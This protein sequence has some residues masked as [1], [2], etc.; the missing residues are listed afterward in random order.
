MCLEPQ[1]H[2]AMHGLPACFMKIVLRKN[3][4]ECACCFGRLPIASNAI[5]YSFSSS[6]HGVSSVGPCCV[7]GREAS[8]VSIQFRADLNDDDANDEK[9]RRGGMA[10]SRALLGVER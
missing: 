8:G 10:R 1:S 6:G 2:M 5:A 3:V 7:G 9:W 4:T